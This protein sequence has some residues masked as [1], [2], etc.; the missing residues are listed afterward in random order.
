MLF[1]GAT[2]YQWMT[3]IDCGRINIETIFTSDFASIASPIYVLGWD[4]ISHETLYRNISRSLRGARSVVRSFQML[5]NSAGVSAADAPTIFQTDTTISTH[6][7]ALSGLRI[8][9]PMRYH[10]RYIHIYRHWVTHMCV[11]KIGH[12]SVRQQLVTC[13]APIQ[14]SYQTLPC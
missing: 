9:S 4:S 11:S 12:H 10:D 14:F 13:L 8:S 6:H 1:K 2:G 3:C 7:L 5:W